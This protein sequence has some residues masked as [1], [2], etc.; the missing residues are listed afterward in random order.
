MKRSLIIA[1]ALLLLTS[2]I[3]KEQT[4][5]AADGQPGAVQPASGK[6]YRD[7]MTGVD[8]SGLDANQKEVALQILNTH[9]CDCGC[10]MT[11]AQCR[12][13]D[14]SCGRSPQLAA[15]VVHALRSGK[16]QG[17]AV[18]DLKQ[19]LRAADP[20]SAAPPPAAQQAQ[21]P[22]V[23]PAANI[24]TADSPGLGPEGA[25]VIIVEYSDFQ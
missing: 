20:P 11:L 4:S 10:G 24:S 7:G 16:G 2:C 15:I 22:T 13:E 18:A 23:I 5:G 3:E 9:S 21:P 8:F 25:R 19:M 6:F 14:Q 12:V 1:A 17:Q